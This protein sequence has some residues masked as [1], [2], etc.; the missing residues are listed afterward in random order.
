MKSFG[1]VAFEAYGRSVG[2]VTHDGRPIPA[3]QDL[4]PAIRQ[5]WE[6]A[7]QAVRVIVRGTETEEN[8]G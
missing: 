2:G 4:T 7:A 1:K 8:A 6:D 3:W 5:A